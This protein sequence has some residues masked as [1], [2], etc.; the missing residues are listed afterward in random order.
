MKHL[1]L[2]RL[3]VEPV[4]RYALAEDFGRRGDV[5]SHSVIPQGTMAQA[6]LRARDA[7]RIAGVEVAL[8]AFELVNRDIKT[9]IRI[10]DGENAEAGAIIAEISGPAADILSAERVALNFVSHLSG[11]ATATASMTKLIANEKS[12]LCCTRKTT[13][14]LRLFEKHAVMCGGGVNHRFGLDDAILIKD[15][16]VALAGGITAA[17]E[18]ARRLQGHMLKLEIEVDTLEQLE[19]ALSAKADAILLDNMG[20]DMLKKAVGIVNGRAITEASGRINPQNILPIAQ[21]GVD[22]I[23]SGWITHSAPILDLGLDIDG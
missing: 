9:G 6:T 1:H 12:K 13:P 11:I 23:S 15:N 7:G 10:P 16:H 19:E 20:P 8:L 22:L 21:S 14:G 3:L 17:I 18:N 2:P 4:V 5:T